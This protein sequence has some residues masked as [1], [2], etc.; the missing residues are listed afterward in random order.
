MLLGKK[1]PKFFVLLSR[2]VIFQFLVSKLKIF[3][4]CSKIPVFPK[5]PCVSR[6]DCRN[7]K[8]LSPPPFGITGR[9]SN[10]PGHDQK[11]HG[12]WSP[13]V[14]IHQRSMAI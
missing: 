14:L 5:D 13:Q 12:D 9:T 4:K 7:L 8:L 11:N 3:K 1:L 6:R 10:L 2:T